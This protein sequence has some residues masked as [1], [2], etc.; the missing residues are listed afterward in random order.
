MGGLLVLVL[1]AG[2]VW[3]A[4]KLVKLVRPYWK[5]VF[6]IVAAILVPTADAVYGRIKLKQMCEA[7]GGLHIYR[8]VERVEG[9]DDPSMVPYEEWISKYGYRVV[10]GQEIG[11]KPSRLV[12][13][14]DGKIVREVGITPT[15][16]YIYETE[17]GNSRNTFDR[18]GSHIRI[19]STGEVLS[20]EVN[21]SYAGGWFE[22]FVA[23]LYAQ[24]GNGGNCGPI[25]SKHELITKTLKPINREQAK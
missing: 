14:A 25:V 9:F 2:Y 7:E 13:Q 15:T 19:R 6:I 18:D 10:E 12:Q 11:G 3:G 24:R 8:V 4:A 17:K 16:Q 22:R 21:I 1:I 20:R 5:K 23:G